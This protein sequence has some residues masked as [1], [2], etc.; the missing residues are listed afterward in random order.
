MKT[1]FIGMILVLSILAAL[2]IVTGGDHANPSVTESVAP[3]VDIGL[4]PLK[5]N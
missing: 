4:Q 5:I 1:R 2:F 3:S